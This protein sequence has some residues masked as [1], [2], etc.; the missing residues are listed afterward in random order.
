MSKKDALR[1]GL[2]LAGEAGISQSDFDRQ[3]KKVEQL[4]VKEALEQGYTHWGYDNRDFQ[5]LSRLEGLME[6][7]F[8]DG[9]AFELYGYIVLAQKEPYYLSI[10][11][12][13]VQEIISDHIMSQDNYCDD[14][15]NTV[16]DALKEVE[17]WDEF[18]VKI[19]AKLKEHP[20]WYLTQIKLIP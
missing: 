7:D 15:F 2:E 20:Y 14:D 9:P 18:A 13:T 8:K 3:N 10:S 11:S 17:G 12:D 6:G 16:P 19:N 4:T 5:H 1:D